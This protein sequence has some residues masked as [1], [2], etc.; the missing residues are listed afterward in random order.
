MI[1]II[2]IFSLFYCFNKKKILFLMKGI[3][4]LKIINIKNIK[5]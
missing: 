5:D 4:N 3:S 2:N 1:I